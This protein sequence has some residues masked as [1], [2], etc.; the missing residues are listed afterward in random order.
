MRSRANLLALQARQLKQRKKDVE[1]AML[2][3]RHKRKENKKLFNEKHQTNSSFNANN[4]VLL[5]DT[6][7]NNHYDI[8]FVPQ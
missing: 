1:K 7:L 3:L 6:K 8:K 5:H 2:Y 4:L